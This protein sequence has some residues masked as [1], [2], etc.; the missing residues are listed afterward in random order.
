MNQYASSQRYLSI[1][2]APNRTE[3]IATGDQVAPLTYPQFLA[4]ARNQV[5]YAKEIHDLLMSAAS[6]ISNPE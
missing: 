6:S 2:V 3:P 4:T 1:V 5:T